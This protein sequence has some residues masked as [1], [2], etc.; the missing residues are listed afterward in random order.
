MSVSYRFWKIIEG[1]N[2]YTLSLLSERVSKENL[3]QCIPQ[4]IRKIQVQYWQQYSSSTIYKPLSTSNYRYY[5]TMPQIFVNY[6]I[7]KSKKIEWPECHFLQVNRTKQNKRPLIQIQ[8][9]KLY[10]PVDVRFYHPGRIARYQ[11]I[12]RHPYTRNLPQHAVFSYCYS[13]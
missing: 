13:L 10:R 12:W 4:P 9:H 2:I 5:I 1:I 8:Q 6:N 3:T 11:G 7:L